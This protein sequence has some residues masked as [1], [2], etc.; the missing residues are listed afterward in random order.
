MRI[1]NIQKL[2]CEHLSCLNVSKKTRNHIFVKFY[3]LSMRYYHTWLLLLFLLKIILKSE[4][5]IFFMKNGPWMVSSSLSGIIKRFLSLNWKIV[6][7]IYEIWCNT[8]F[9]NRGIIFFFLST[10][11]GHWWG[12]IYNIYSL[13]WFFLVWKYIIVIGSKVQ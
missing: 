2:L 13:L 1:G 6:S 3:Y 5:I 4:K 10:D 8:Y 11:G 7:R 12:L 9:D